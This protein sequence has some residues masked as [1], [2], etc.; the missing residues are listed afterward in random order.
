MAAKNIVLCTDGTWNGPDDSTGQSVFEGPN[1]T[2]ELSSTALTNV[3]KLYANLEGATIPDAVALRNEDE[4][5]LTDGQGNRTQVCKY[6][7]GV[8]DSSNPLVRFLGGVF[9]IG[10]V[11]RI[12]RGYT[13]I[14]RYYEPGD[15]IFICGFS[16]GAY[17]ARSLADMIATV[18]LLDPTTYDPNSKMDAY[19]L[20]VAAWAKAKTLQLAGN[21]A[22]A[23]VGDAVVGDIAD[24]LAASL[25]AN[26]LRKIDSICAVAVWDTVGSMGIPTYAKGART[27]VFRLINTSLDPKILNGIHAMAVDELRADFPVT[28]W[29]VRSGVQQTWFVGA[30]ADVGGGY[31]PNESRLSDLT[32][33]WMMNK[34]KPLGV[35]YPAAL[36]YTPNFGSAL[37]QAIHTPWLNNPFDRLGHDKR[38]VLAGE[39][40]HSSVRARWGADATYRP[41]ALKGLLP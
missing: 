41:L 39:D 18:G 7:H 31:P 15:K 33:D 24:F 3:V 1:A 20:G 14:S 28:K 16:R 6:I 19:R 9:G 27:D 32:L 12:V 5:I 36:S 2:N 21:N 38:D 23:K 11:T 17:T 40:L 25:K 10:V 35:L 34:L 26:S 37:T 4:K 29:A 22:L 13:F 8:G 30:H